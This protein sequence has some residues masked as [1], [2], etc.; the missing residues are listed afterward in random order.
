MCSLLW[1]FIA[2]GKYKER[3]R[4]SGGCHPPTRGLPW[5]QPDLLLRPSRSSPLASDALPLSPL[6]HQKDSP[7]PTG[8]RVV[9]PFWTRAILDLFTK[10]KLQVTCSWSWSLVLQWK[11]TPLACTGQASCYIHY[12]HCPTEPSRL[13]CG[14]PFM[15]R[16]AQV[17]GTPCSRS[18]G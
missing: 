2:K 1:A 5:G 13:C 18:R 10:N 8:A 6:C 3:K 15:G 11:V 16:Q 7:H 14:F 9:L 4:T 17:G 12:T